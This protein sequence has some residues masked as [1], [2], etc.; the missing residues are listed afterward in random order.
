MKTFRW[1][2]GGVIIFL[3]LLMTILDALT[4]GGLF[5]NDFWQFLRE[6]WT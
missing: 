3:I 1:I 2:I 4:W 6:L 5:K